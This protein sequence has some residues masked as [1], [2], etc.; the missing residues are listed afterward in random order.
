MYCAES[1]VYHSHNFKLRELYSRYKL[2]G[3]FFKQNSYLDKYGT[4]AS[5][6]SLARYVFKRSIEERNIKAIMR[7]PLDMGVRF[8]GMKVGKY[9]K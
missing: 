8:I 6:G 3:K 9:G 1:V 5:G 4:N 2:T 7:F